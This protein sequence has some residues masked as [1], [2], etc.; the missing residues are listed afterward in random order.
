MD[1]VIFMVNI[2]E[3]RKL[4]YYGVGFYSSDGGEKFLIILVE[5]VRGLWFDWKMFL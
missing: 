1:F 5:F 2:V 3:S 4:E